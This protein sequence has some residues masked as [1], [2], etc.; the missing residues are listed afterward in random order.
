ME[1]LPQPP[2]LGFRE[3]EAYIAPLLPAL[4]PGGGG[5]LSS[6]SSAYAAF[7]YEGVWA[8]GFISLFLCAWW[9]DEIS[10]RLMTLSDGLKMDLSVVASFVLR[11]RS[12]SRSIDAL[13]W[14]KRE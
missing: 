14:K 10:I 2:S 13:R 12:R 3:V 8:S 6:A 7:V 4:V 11:M 1:G 9:S 5:S